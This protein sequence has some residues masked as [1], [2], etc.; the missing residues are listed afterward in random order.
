MADTYK[1]LGQLNPAA[2]SLLALYTV[3]ADTQTTISTI[4][5]CN[6]S[7]VAT[8]FRV[9]VAPAGD[10]DDPMHYIAYDASID[11]NDTIYVTIGITLAATDEVRVYAADATLSFSAFGVEVA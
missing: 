8:T 1:V 4:V 6:R 11:G 3:P 10:T 2:T 5:V 7:N 9:S